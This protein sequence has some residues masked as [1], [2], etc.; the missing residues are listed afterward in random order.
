MRRSA[1]P[2]TRSSL[3]TPQAK[4][5]WN[6][7]RGHEPV[8]CDMPISLVK[9]S[10]SIWP[11]LISERG[12]LLTTIRL[13]AAFFST[14]LRRLR[15]EMTTRSRAARLER[16]KIW[17]PLAKARNKWTLMRIATG[18]ISTHTPPCPTA[19][20][21]LLTTAITFGCRAEKRRRDSSSSAT[22][23]T[24]IKSVP[25]PRP[26]PGMRNET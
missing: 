21:Y 26:S 24:T 23:R 16:C 15:S 5:R 2:V 1:L 14:T 10:I 20:E 8:H 4:Q 12:S 6:C 18:A 25:V 7:Q 9:A 13:T 19:R 22:Y 3:A 11:R 17:T